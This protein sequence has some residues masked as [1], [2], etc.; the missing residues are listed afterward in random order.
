MLTNDLITQMSRGL[1]SWGRI[2]RRG[3][4]LKSQIQIQLSKRRSKSTT[5]LGKS[6]KM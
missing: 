6:T 4:L 5:T 2:R 1:S 3:R